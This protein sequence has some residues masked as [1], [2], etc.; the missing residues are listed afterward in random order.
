MKPAPSSPSPDIECLFA[1]IKDEMCCS[2]PAVMSEDDLQE[3]IDGFHAAIQKATMQ[4]NTEVI[5]VMGMRI[6]QFTK[7][8]IQPE[9]P[10]AHIQLRLAHQ[11]FNTR[12]I[13]YEALVDE[14]NENSWI[15]SKNDLITRAIAL[16][17]TNERKQMI[18]DCYTTVLPNGKILCPPPKIFDQL[19]QDALAYL[20]RELHED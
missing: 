13:V 9:S 11:N 10:D 16:L 18:F 20:Q 8:V 15:Y 19:M 17:N 7:N 2:M 14:W 6:E 5:T 12:R 1:R 3:K 4:R